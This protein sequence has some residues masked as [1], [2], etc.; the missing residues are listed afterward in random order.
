MGRL[1]HVVGPGTVVVRPHTQLEP[2]I[3][4]YSARFAPD[5]DWEK[6]TE[7][8]VAYCATNFSKRGF[9][10]STRN[11]GSSRSHAGVRSE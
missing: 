10:F 11:T 2:D 3:L 7:R 6:V 5:V 4:V 8:F 9:P 1:R